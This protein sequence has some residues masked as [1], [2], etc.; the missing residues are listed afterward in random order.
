MESNPHI[1]CMKEGEKTW[2]VSASLSQVCNTSVTSHN[3]EPVDYNRTCCS[4]GCLRWRNPN[5]L[6]K[7][8]FMSRKSTSMFYPIYLPFKIGFI[9]CVWV[10][11]VN[12]EDQRTPSVSQCLLLLLESHRSNMSLGICQQV[13]L[14]TEKSSWSLVTICI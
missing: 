14:T 7:L 1:C 11:G 5:W 4:L 8:N 3:I 6:G 12:V 10:Q 2:C 9:C 13:P